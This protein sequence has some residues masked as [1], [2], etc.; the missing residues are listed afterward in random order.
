[1]FA[2]L[3]VEVARQQ[4]S[5]LGEGPKFGDEA[6]IR[7]IHGDDEVELPEVFDRER[8]GALVADAKPGAG[9]DLDAP[10]IG[11]F[12]TMKGR[13]SRAVKVIGQRQVGNRCVVL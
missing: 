11:R 3:R 2:G 10:G 4:E 1:V 5:L 8:S 13:G 6:T 7:A 12:P 9:C